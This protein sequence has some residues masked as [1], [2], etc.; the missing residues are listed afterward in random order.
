M[1]HVL[2]NTNLLSNE[3]EVY[4][5]NYH[6]EIRLKVKFENSNVQAMLVCDRL[7]ITQSFSANI[8]INDISL[9]LDSSD[10]ISAAQS[11]GISSNTFM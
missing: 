3:T 7:C 11:V 2:Q 6:G 8:A 4:K 10:Y 1:V 5:K 9:K